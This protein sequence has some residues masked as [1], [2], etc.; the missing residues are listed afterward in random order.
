L[1]CG[2]KA[3]LKVARYD[4]ENYLMVWRHRFK[5]FEVYRSMA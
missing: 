2:Q 5:A 1:L 4:C 3:V